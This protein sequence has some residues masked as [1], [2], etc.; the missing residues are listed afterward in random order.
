MSAGPSTGSGTQAWLVGLDV[1]GTIILEDESMSP[2]VPEAVARLRDA[3]HEVM[4]A[5]GRSWSA[6]QRYVEELGLTS[7]FVVCS[8]GAVTMR[9]VDDG[10]ERWHVETFDP[11]PVLTLLRDHLPEANYMVELGDGTRLYT[12]HLDD[13]TLDDGRQVEFEELAAE[14]VSRVVVVS[15]GHDEDDFHRL[16]AD[17]GLNQVSYAIG[18]TAW[19]DIAPQ[20]VD[21]GTALE[22]VRTEL[23]FGHGNVLVAGDGRN[24]IGMFGWALGIDGRAVAMGQ[25]PDEVKTAAGEVTADVESGGL[26]MALDTLP[27]PAQVSAGE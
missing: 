18:W 27:A 16:V 3:G 4:I 25:G 8:N 20:G 11:E 5:T 9:R 6:T 26:A 13:W 19:L 12:Q 2:G 1:D 23:G 15:P 7:R 17:A 10:W 24:D 21:K 22:R 14:P